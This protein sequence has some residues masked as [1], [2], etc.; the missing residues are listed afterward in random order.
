MHR[1]CPVKMFIE[2]WEKINYN[3]QNNFIKTYN[4]GSWINETQEKTSFTYSSYRSS[5]FIA[6]IA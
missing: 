2:F 5:G 3:I 1:R 4:V 6:C